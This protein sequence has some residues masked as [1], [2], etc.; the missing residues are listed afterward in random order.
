MSR[1][2]CLVAVLVASSIAL[3]AGIQSQTKP[4]APPAAP[5]SKTAVIVFETAKGAL[6]IETYSDAPQSVARILELVRRGFYRG[7][8][9]HWTQPGVVQFGDPLSRD[10]TKEADWGTGGSGP[11]NTLRPIGVAETSKRPFVLGTVG[12]AYR[13]GKKPDTAD[14]QLFILTGPNPALNG[15]YAAIGHVTKGIEVVAKLEKADLIKQAYVKG[16][17]PK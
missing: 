1:P 8:R 7:Q 14:S 2:L 11:R 6:E 4:A 9:V 12:L 17:T 5:A 10:M 3:T 16:E 13:T 15:K